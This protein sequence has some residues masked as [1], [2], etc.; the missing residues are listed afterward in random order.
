MPGRRLSFVRNTRTSARIPSQW[1]LNQVANIWEKDIVADHWRKSIGVKKVRLKTK[2]GRK[3]WVRNQKLTEL[4]FGK[5]LILGKR[6][7]LSTSHWT[8]VTLRL[9]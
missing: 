8:I 5:R 6:I 3:N 4:R 1:V 2:T 7:L 9:I